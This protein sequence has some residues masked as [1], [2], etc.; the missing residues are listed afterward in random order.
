MGNIL[1]GFN[2][3]LDGFIEDAT[4]NFDWSTPDE[5]SHRHFNDQ[6]RA[7]GLHLYGRG[8]WE[9][10]KVWAT[11]DTE[12][13]M[14]EYEREYARLWQKVPTIVFSRTLTE[15]PDGVRIVR[16]VDAVEIRELKARTEGDLSLGGASLA[17]EFRRLGLVDEYLVYVVPVL[18]GSGKPMFQ[19]D[20]IENLHLLDVRTFASGVTLLRYA[21]T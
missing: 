3:S 7:T 20:T 4:G 14:A 16:E 1:Y 19:G 13:S 11:L 21:P 6:E 9:V 18:V 5:E 2:V 15:V 10:M 12:P 8:L 17:A